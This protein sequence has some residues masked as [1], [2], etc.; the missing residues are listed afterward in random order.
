MANKELRQWRQK[1]H[2]IVDPLWKRRHYK[3]HTVYKRLSEAFGEPVHIGE[4]NIERCK[5]I[6]QNVPLLFN[7]PTT[8]KPL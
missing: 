7:L 4:S 3:R 5:E 8:K 1:A 6:I 2:A